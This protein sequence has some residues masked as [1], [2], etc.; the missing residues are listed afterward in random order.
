MKLI[1]F[2]VHLILQIVNK[3]SHLDK[4]LILLCTPNL[5]TLRATCI[6]TVRKREEYLHL[7]DKSKIFAA[8]DFNIQYFPSTMKGLVMKLDGTI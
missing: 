2:K 3:S 1:S 6:Y 8:K 5:L 7:F 4:L